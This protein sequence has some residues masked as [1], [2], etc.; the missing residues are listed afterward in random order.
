MFYRISRFPSHITRSHTYQVQKPVLKRH[1]QKKARKSLFKSYSSLDAC[2]SHFGKCFIEKIAKTRSFDK[3]ILLKTLM[4]RK[5]IHKSPQ[6]ICSGVP[7]SIERR[8]KM[9]M[10]M[11]NGVL[12]FYFCNYMSCI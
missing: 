10:K 11:L 6:L 9:L 7:V 2:E 4:K 12:R 8:K 1:I 3:K 5:L